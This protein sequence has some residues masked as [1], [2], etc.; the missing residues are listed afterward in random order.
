[1]FKENAKHLYLDSQQV[2]VKSNTVV[3]TD[4]G[5]Q[6]EWESVIG[7]LKEFEYEDQIA[8]RWHVAGEGKPIIIDPRVNND[9][10][11]LASDMPAQ[12]YLV[13]VLKFLQ[14]PDH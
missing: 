12:R 11:A 8:L 5:G 1:K 7:R 14:P 10:L 13:L 3:Q 9:R 4:T 6:L 2:D